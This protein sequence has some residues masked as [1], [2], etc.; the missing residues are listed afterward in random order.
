MHLL[1]RHKVENFVRWRDTFESH[2]K[3]QREAG[4]EL[5]QLWR[6]VDEPDEVVLLFDVE[7]IEKAKEF[8]Y[9]ADVPDAKNGSGVVDEPDIYFLE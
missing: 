8:V 1:V 6:N 2:R 3:A 4:I 9:S 5:K 7:D